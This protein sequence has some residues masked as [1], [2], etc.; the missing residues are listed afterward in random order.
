MSKYV[1]RSGDKESD[2]LTV[3][4]T[5]DDQEPRNNTNFFNISSILK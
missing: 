3:L 5:N 1:L 4:V 2:N